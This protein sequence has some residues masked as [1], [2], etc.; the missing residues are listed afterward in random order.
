MKQLPARA[1]EM[2]G[3]GKRG[4]PRRRPQGKVEIPNQD[5]HFS[6]RQVGAPTNL[7]KEDSPERR[8]RRPSGS[9]F[10]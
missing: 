6:P 1:V 2:T 7:K 10:D 9:F 5:S 8:L 3:Y 4:K